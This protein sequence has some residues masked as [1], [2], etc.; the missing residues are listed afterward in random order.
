MTEFGQIIGRA[1]VV[2][3]VADFGRLWIETY[4]EPVSEQ[5]GYDSPI[6]NPRSWETSPYPSAVW[7]PE[8]QVTRVHVGCPGTESVDRDGDGAYG[9]AYLVNVWVFCAARDED[10]TAKLCDAYTRAIR[11]LFVQH[12]S[13]GGFARSLRWTGETF[14][15]D[16]E[17]DRR[18][19]ALG[20]NSFE[21]QVADLV[22]DGMG[23]SAPVPPGDEG[24]PTQITDTE[25]VVDRS[26]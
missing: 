18:T 16:D 12:R 21:V 17:D 14:G 10:S 23:P 26:D 8:D 13:V 15:L 9:G 2:A 5:M 24:Y 7:W 6:P 4:L 1:E 25:A 22:N 3:A 20:Q 11:A 19:M